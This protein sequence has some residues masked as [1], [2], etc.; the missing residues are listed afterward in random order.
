MARRWRW[1]P[2]DPELG[3]TPFAW[4]LY[5]GFVFMVPAAFMD[6]AGPLVWGSSIVACLL[7]LPLYFRAYWVDGRPRLLLALG[8]TALGMALAP[9][10]PGSNT[11]FIYAAYFAGMSTISLAGGAVRVG[12]V[13]LA[14]LVTELVLQ[15]GPYFW[16]PPAVGVV[17]IGAFGM[18][19]VQ[20]ERVHAS[21][22]LAREE[23]AALARIA[24]R[25]R[26][27]RDLH[28]LLGHSL[29]VVALKAELAEKLVE[30]DPGRARKEM[31]D[32]R[33]VAREALSE[34]RT[35]VRG[36]RVGSGAGLRQELGRAEQALAAAEVELRCD[37]DP[38]VVG[39]HTDATHEAVL[40]L[41]LR[42]ATTNV[43]RHAR[44][45]TC[46]IRFFQAADD[47]F[48]LEVRD[49][50]RGPSDRPGHGLLGMRE[51]VE[52]V[53]GRL[54]IGPATPGTRLVARFPLVKALRAPKASD[55]SGPSRREAS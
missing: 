30:R 17:V 36:Y 37:G 8:I 1:L 18:Q 50:G 5:L 14:L 16:A 34:V 26:I 22:R 19:Q 51:R 43:V 15:A 52:A 21:L 28:D 39:P 45:R 53:G 38:E 23:V 44:A 41:V 54:E 3:S 11:F 6:D 13:G 9:I 31:A 48:G 29:S 24:E 32:V 40:A 55:P 46:E 42:E 27:A 20:R 35:A 10:N 12:M 7:F 33:D 25:E 2:D 49:D 4:L 47:C